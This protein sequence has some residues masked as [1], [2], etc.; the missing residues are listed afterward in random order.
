MTDVQLEHAF[1]LSCHP[2]L[3]HL[4]A[5][6]VKEVEDE[7]GIAEEK[8]SFGP[9]T[10][11]SLAAGKGRGGLQ[12]SWQEFRLGVLRYLEE[13]GFGGVPRLMY[14]TMKP[15]MSGGQPAGSQGQGQR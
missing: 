3:V 6:Y 9:V 2:A 7:V 14:N 1:G 12:M 5:D 4:V 8:R 15:L 13:R 11:K 10:Q